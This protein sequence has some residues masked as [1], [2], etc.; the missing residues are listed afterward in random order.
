MNALKQKIGKGNYETEHL[1]HEWLTDR[2]DQGT[3]AGQLVCSAANTLNAEETEQRAAEQRDE[4]DTTDTLVTEMNALERK[5]YVIGKKIGEGSFATVHLAYYTDRISSKKV[6]IACKILDKEVQPDDRSEFEILKKVQHPHIIHVHDI[7]NRG[8]NVFIFMELAENGDLFDFIE[9]NGEVPEE[10]AKTWFLQMTSAVQYLH[11]NNIA[12]RD[13]K[14]ENILFS[15]EYDVKLADFGFACFSVNRDG[16]HVLRETFCG[17]EAYAAPE[18]LK[19]QP[20][21]PKLGDVWSL[22]VIL[23]IMLNRSMPFDSSDHHMQYKDQ[24]DR[25]YEFEPQVLDTVSASAISAVKDMLEPDMTL[26]PN[27]DEVMAH[28]WLTG[29]KDQ[30]TSSVG[31]LVTSASNTL[32]AAETQQCAT[33]Q[34]EETDTTETRV[35][36][37]NVKNV[38]SNDLR[39]TVD[40]NMS[41][42][43]N[44]KP[45]HYQKKSCFQNLF[46]CLIKG[47]QHTCTIISQIIPC[48][49]KKK[50][51]VVKVNKVFT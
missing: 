32:Y 33:E 2:E 15:C 48:F 36:T 29:R 44:D 38:S 8:S 49:K 6:T 24:M 30:C 46:H 22:G 5:R 1:A 31:Q 43:D 12:H 9:S 11:N 25:N 42:K 3:S 37:D 28:V 47:F 50:N 18:I 45:K 51:A 14:C 35:M 10:K 13:L 41:G 23:F 27:I 19:Q 7:L 39:N 26:R 20:Y 21:D 17:T 40:V 4:P 34:S 16:H